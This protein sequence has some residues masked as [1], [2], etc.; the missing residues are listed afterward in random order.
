MEELKPGDHVLINAAPIG[1]VFNE[2]VGTLG[3]VVETSSV[4]VLVFVAEGNEYWYDAKSVEPYADYIGPNFH[5]GPL[6]V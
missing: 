4:A 3:V 5:R 1:F 2:N 6:D